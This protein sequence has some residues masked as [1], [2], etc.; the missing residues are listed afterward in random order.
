MRRDVYGRKD[1]KPLEGDIIENYYN[2]KNIMIKIQCG[3]SIRQYP[4]LRGYFN[5]RIYDR[6]SEM[7]LAEEVI[8]NNLFEGKG[9]T[10]ST[11]KYI[12]SLSSLFEDENSKREISVFAANMMIKLAQ[13]SE[14]RV[15]RDLS[16]FDI[17]EVTGK[18]ERAHKIIIEGGLVDE[19]MSPYQV[20]KVKESVYVELIDI[21]NRHKLEPFY[22]FMQSKSCMRIPQF[23]D[24]FGLIGGKPADEFVI[25]HLVETSWFRGIRNRDQ[26]YVEAQV[27]R[28]AKIY[29][30]CKISETGTALQY[31][32]FINKDVSVVEGDCGTVHLLPVFINDE[33]DL[34]CHHG[35]NYSMD[36]DGKK[37]IKCDSKD[38]HLIG[39]TLY[40]RTPATCN[41]IHG[42]LC[43]TCVGVPVLKNFDFGLDCSLKIIGATGQIMLSAKHIMILIAALHIKDKFIK[44]INNTISNKLNVSSEVASIYLDDYESDTFIARSSRL[45]VTLV[46]GE[47]ILIDIMD[48]NIKVKTTNLDG[49]FIKDF[50]NIEIENR[51]RPKS[52][53][54]YVLTRNVFS[55]K[56]EKRPYVETVGI[57]YNTLRD[58]YHAAQI[59]TLLHK[60]LRNPE[61]LYERFDFTDPN[62]TLDQGLFISTDKLLKFLP[63][64]DSLQHG[65]AVMEHVLLAPETYIGKRPTSDTMDVILIP[66]R[67]EDLVKIIDSIDK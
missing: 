63:F 13:F 8:V 45:L 15:S 4:M 40:F 38:K 23:V 32:M 19:S 34:K 51:N 9:D 44:Y 39:K 36:K 60:H 43:S 3:N 25:P 49:R 67:R 27:A 2:A 10:P 30:K 66:R 16:F 22:T 65:K 14:N 7:N 31:S 35:M 41:H 57:A 6:L 37:Y 12:N 61:C 26:H 24:C 46:S 1:I 11:L 53:V 62:K 17:F 56:S 18:D 64:N 50:N 21:V 52:K 55:S 47:E 29:E 42:S 5:L 54:F 33:R 48:T 58:D 59:Y 28:F 20:M